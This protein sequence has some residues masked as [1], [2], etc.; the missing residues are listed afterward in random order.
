MRS[1]FKGFTLSLLLKTLGMEVDEISKNEVV[2]K[3][4]DKVNVL[5]A[6]DNAKKI[7]LCLLVLSI[8]GECDEDTAENKQNLFLIQTVFEKTAKKTTAKKTTKKAKES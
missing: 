4:E 3:D 2:V 6:N 1:Y 8:L 7:D 5:L